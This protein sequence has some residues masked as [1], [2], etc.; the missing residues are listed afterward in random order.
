[1]NVDLEMMDRI[2]VQVLLGGSVNGGMKVGEYGQCT[3][4]TYMK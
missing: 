1:M 2:V 3:L 4:Y